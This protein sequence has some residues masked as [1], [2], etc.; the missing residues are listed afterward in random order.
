MYLFYCPDILSTN[1]LSDK[2]ATHCVNVLRLKIND[3][4]HVTDGIGNLYK[5]EINNISNKNISLNIIDTQNNFMPL[6]Y[7]LHIAIS[8][9]KNIDRIEYFVEKAT[10]IGISE[11]SFL[12]CRYSERKNVN[13]DR[14]K[15]IAEA[16]MKQSYKAFHPKI[17]ELIPFSN[18][19]KLQF[20]EEQKF[21]AH[22]YPDS[23]SFLANNVTK[24]SSYLVLIGP[25]GD[26]SEEEVSIAKNNG[27]LPISLGSSRLRTET[28]AL[29]ATT[30]ISVI[31]NI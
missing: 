10:E 3:I 16:A 8:A 14:I 15:R 20:S 18:F 6:P 2:E 11:I 26:F 9:T 1:S 13:T 7:N 28:A 25:E 21:I 23:K 24:N 17:N 30:L 5:A 31:N 22:C 27:F 12:N 4:V 19:M 29:Y